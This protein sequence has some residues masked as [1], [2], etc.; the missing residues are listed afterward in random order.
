MFSKDAIKLYVLGFFLLGLTAWVFFRENR[1]DWSDY[2]AEFRELV[3]EKFGEERAAQVPSG[4]QQVWVKDL[5]RVDRCITCHQAVEWKG[6]ENAPEPYRTHPKEIL[7]KHPLSAYACTSC[8]G[9]QGF[10]T[11]LPDAHGN[12]EHWEEPLL[13]ADVRDAYLIKNNKA[14]MEMNCNSCHRYDRETKGMEYINMAKRLVE[15]KNCRACHTING[16][17]GI[18][19]P[20]LTFEGDKPTEQFDYSRLS[21][22]H[23]VFSWQV[24]HFQN[25]KMVSPESVMPNFGFS[26]QQAHALSLLVMS[27][28]REA[29][30]AHYISGVQLRDVPTQEEIDK[31]KR[32]LEGEGAFF[33]KN[34]CF[35]CHSVSSFGI[36][37][38]SKIGPDLSDAVTDVQ[39]RFGRT[40]DDF[41]MEP[42]GTM[43]VVLATQIPLTKEQRQEAIALLKVAHQRKLE[44]QIRNASPSPTPVG[45]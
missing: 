7:E 21:G 8:H 26:S 44:Q 5:D 32:M 29:I 43:S 40:L 11:T 34:S 18:I 38:A 12:V 39:S 6:M 28:R 15:E 10:S 25:P 2:Q 45:K 22:R 1:T 35:I 37:S 3:T 17:G 14:L 16:R 23:S 27:W 9:G 30:P 4:I 41:L 19:G 33:V 31:E 13:G 20:D 36:E 42:T 24:A